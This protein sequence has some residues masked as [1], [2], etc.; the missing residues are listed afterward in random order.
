MSFLVDKKRFSGSFFAVALSKEIFA[1][2][3]IISIPIC[4][5]SG[6]N[7]KAFRVFRPA[8]GEAPRYVFYKLQLFLHL[9]PFICLVFERPLVS[10]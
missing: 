9:L 3:N 6:S 2:Q 1:L 8:S 10:I 4:D 7:P 5:R